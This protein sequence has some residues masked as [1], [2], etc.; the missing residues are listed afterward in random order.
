MHHLRLKPYGGFHSDHEVL[1]E[2]QL[3]AQRLALPPELVGTVA[4]VLHLFL[5]AFGTHQGWWR[6]LSVTHHEQALA[7]ILKLRQLRLRPHLR[8]LRCESHQ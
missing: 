3:C 6:Q 4:Q 1:L 7:L 2:F 5:N 8:Q